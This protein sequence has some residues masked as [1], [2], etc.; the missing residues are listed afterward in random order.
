MFA[1]LLAGF[2]GYCQA[3]KRRVGIAQ[4]KMPAP[5][6]IFLTEIQSFLLNKCFLT[7]VS[8]WLISRVRKKLILIVFASVLVDFIEEQI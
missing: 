6:L 1:R 7:T 4:V 5:K 3:G 8:L 2:Q